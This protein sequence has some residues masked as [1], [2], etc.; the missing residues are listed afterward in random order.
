MF[1]LASVL[2]AACA[3]MLVVSLCDALAAPNVPVIKT[4]TT[5]PTVRWAKSFGPN[6]AYETGL[7]TDGVVV[8][9]RIK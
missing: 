4:P 1:C 2:V 3:V 6:E 7:R 5:E 8:W 9:R